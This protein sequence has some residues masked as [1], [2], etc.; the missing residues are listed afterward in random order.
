MAGVGRPDDVEVTTS[1]RTT[2]PGPPQPAESGK[3]VAGPPDVTP[4]DAV[5]A[6]GGGA[7]VVSVSV[8]FTYTGKAVSDPATVVT[9]T[10]TCSVS[11]VARGLVVDGD[12]PL[13]DG[14]V[15]DDVH[16]N[17]VR[18]VSD[19]PLRVVG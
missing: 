2:H 18:I 10:S 13:L 11:G 7:V 19:A 17:A 4:R 12:P 6:S 8:T 16:G 3:W 9:A 1:T 5:S 15:D 14:D